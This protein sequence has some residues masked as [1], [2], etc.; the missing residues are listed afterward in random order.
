MATNKLDQPTYWS[1]MVFLLGLTK[2]PMLAYVRPKVTAI[3][4]EEVRVKIRLRRRTRNHLRSMYFG[5]L[6]VGAD[7]AAGIHAFYYS[8]KEKLPISF[9][10]K[11]VQGQFHQR[12]MSDVEFVCGEGQ[13]IAEAV[14]EAKATGERINQPVTVQAFDQKGE[15]VADFIMT[16]SVKIPKRS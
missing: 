8:R 5:A 15:L 1:R 3:S 13:L 4:K 16:I 2:I 14:Q 9:A 6:A 7:T 12:A 10:F 11:A